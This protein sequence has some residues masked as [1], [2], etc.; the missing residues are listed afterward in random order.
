MTESMIMIKDTYVASDLVFAGVKRHYACFFRF[1]AVLFLFSWMFIGISCATGQGMTN[2][3]IAHNDYQI[4]QA[5]NPDDGNGFDDNDGF[6]DSDDFSDEFNDAFDDFDDFDEFDEFD[7]YDV[8]VFDPLSRYNRVMTT[9]NDRVYLWLLDPTARAYATVTPVQAR[10]SINRFFRNLGY[11]SRLVNNLLQFKGEGALK[12][13]A[14]F[15]VNS[16]IGLLG[17][18]DP[19]GSWLGI[20]PHKEDFGLTL[21]KYGAGNGFHIVIPLLGPSNLRDGVG[22]IVDSF[23][24]PVFYLEGFYIATAAKAADELNYASLHIGEY[25]KVRKEAIDLYVFLRN[26]YEQNREMQ[27]RE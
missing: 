15:T 25:E 10:Q 12:E 20:E 2:S 18:F 7:R 3:S 8:D 4:D 27:I 6:N 21:G 24:D 26:A 16:T 5:D 14:R 19:A 22:L 23:L 13:T 9:F 11:P 17:F 1:L